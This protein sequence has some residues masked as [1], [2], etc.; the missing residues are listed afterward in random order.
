MTDKHSLKAQRAH[1]QPSTPSL[2]DQH[3]LADRMEAIDFMLINEPM[4]HAPID[5][6]DR[7]LTAIAAGVRPNSEH[8]LYRGV[9]LALGLTLTVFFIAPMML[10]SALT[11]I[12]WITDPSAFGNLLRSI[13]QQVA[14][15]LDGLMQVVA[16]SL[17]FMAGTVVGVQGLILLC[18]VPIS[19][20]WIMTLWNAQRAQVV[21]RIPV[22]VL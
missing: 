15:M 13:F 2:D 8:A 4:L 21:Y 19:V 3:E 22:Q 10:M 11:L 1:V 9:R 14:L 17:Q 12:H 20:M 7:V 5:F 6:A 16:A 18:I